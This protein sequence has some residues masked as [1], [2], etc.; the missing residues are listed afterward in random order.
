MAL[1]EL[2]TCAHAVGDI[3]LGYQISKKL[4]E[5][6]LV[7]DE[8]NKKRI[9]QNFKSYEQMVMKHQANMYEQ[10]L[11]QKIQTKEVFDG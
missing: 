4:L 10:S 8:D 6:D 5:S 1:D 3:H 9:Y 11:S 7:P 2:A